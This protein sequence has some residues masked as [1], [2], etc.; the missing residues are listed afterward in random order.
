[1]SRRPQEP[2]FTSYYGRPIL[3]EP[4]WEATDI[5]GY[6]FTGGLAG[7]SSIL[8]A[9][10]TA[11]RRPRT[12]RAARLGALGAI[13]VSAVALVHDLGKPGRFYNMLRVAKPTSPM[14]MGSWLLAAY[15]PLVGV[16]A[17]ADLT[18]IAPRLGKSAGMGAAVLG[19]GVASYTAV[20]LADTAVPAWHESRAELPFVFVGSAASAAA[21]LSLLTAPLTE[22]GPA[23]QVGVVGAVAELAAAYQ[24]EHSHGVIAE[25][26]S[27]GR[28]GTLLRAARACTAVGAVAAATVAR[29]SRRG[30]IVAGAGLLAGSAFTRFG[31]F[32]A[33]RNSTRDPKYVVV[34]QRERLA[35]AERA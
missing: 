22:A 21:G 16:T 7:A 20:L 25:A 6:L 29:R 1:M 11:T 5:A 12:A 24:M 34:P 35:V 10:A 15:G 17:A 2:S 23:R 3:K 28:A 19:A 14:S 8:A 27:T 30:A 32:E 4:T 33:G 31:I 18:G 9:C 13:G 26:F